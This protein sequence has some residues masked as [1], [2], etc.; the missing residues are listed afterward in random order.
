MAFYRGQAGIMPRGLPSEQDKRLGAV[1]FGPHR[2]RKPSLSWLHKAL[3][4]PSE[5][6]SLC[7][8]IGQRESLSRGELQ[9]ASVLDRG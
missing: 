9:R 3:R 6:A 7:F 8:P 1:V 2:E 5:A 4:T